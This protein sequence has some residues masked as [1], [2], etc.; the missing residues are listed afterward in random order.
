MK[1]ELTPLQKLGLTYL[2]IRSLFGIAIFL[3]V[4]VAMPLWYIGNA[5][6]SGLGFFFVLF[7]VWGLWMFTRGK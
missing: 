1:D 2:G 3:A 4:F 5:I 6:I 7:F